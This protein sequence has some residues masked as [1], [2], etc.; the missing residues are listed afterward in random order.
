MNPNSAIATIQTPNALPTVNRAGTLLTDATE[1]Q[2]GD[3]ISNTSSAP[4]EIK[5]PARAS[6][7]GATLLVLQP[8]AAARLEQLISELADGASRTKVVALSQGV[9]L[10]DIDDDV[11]SA[12]LEQGDGDGMAGLV[13]AGLLAGGLGGGAL[14]ALGA[15]AAG[16]FLLSD[17]NNDGTG[18]SASGGAGGVAG[19]LD[20][21]G[22]G[23]DQTPLA[24][25]SQVTDAVSGGLTTVGGALGGA[26]GSDPTG[27]T[28][29]LTGVV[30]DPSSGDGSSA[31]GLVGAVNSV[32]TGLDSGAA[33]TPL[34][35]VVDPLTETLGSNSGTV[36][37]VAQGLSDV[38]NVL[39][40]DSS[41]LAPVTA[42]LLAP[43]VGTNP[44]SGTANG[45]PGTLNEVS[46]GLTDLTAAD[47]ALA[48]LDPATSGVGG[49]V[50]T[51]ASGVETVG[52]AVTDASSQDPTGTI[53]LVGDV[54]GG[55][56]ASTS[57]GGDTALPGLDTLP[58]S[59][60]PISTD[61]GLT[62]VLDPVTSALPI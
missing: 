27:L 58:T 4:M 10:F 35:P 1:L 61:A 30:G 34:A 55:D 33:D 40:S 19:A 62:T 38:G 50:D 39:A 32:S 44:D 49:A 24:P 28:D 17:N 5:I 23:L 52:N 45:L 47:S 9:E 25:V 20:S 31:T 51:L 42:D 11:A 36:D 41:P 18:S 15:G 57:T 14:A 59:S 3:Q 22:S 13:G 60:L 21:V 48:P 6:G 37:G 54:L 16:V 2:W 7:Q 26:S 53:A 56:T 43:I 12:V 29:V 46:E 8:G